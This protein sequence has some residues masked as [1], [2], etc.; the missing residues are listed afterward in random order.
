M[1]YSQQFVFALSIMAVMVW[2]AV[3]GGMGQ[4][5]AT[6]LSWFV[7]PVWLIINIATF[8]SR[9]I[10]ID[11]ANNG[12]LSGEEL[13]KFNKLA[14]ILRGRPALLLWIIRPAWA[15]S[16]LIIIAYG[17]VW[18]GGMLFFAYWLNVMSS[19]AVLDVADKMAAKSEA[20]S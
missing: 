11:K 17:W 18:L 12:K 6:N 8:F 7:L 9:C 4:Q 19:W 3:F 2:L 16:Y 20:M 5:W 15:V 13:A 10:K 14:D 1:K